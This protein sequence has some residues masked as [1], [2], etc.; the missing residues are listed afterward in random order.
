[1]PVSTRVW[2]CFLAGFFALGQ[3]GCNMAPKSWHRQAALRNQELYKQGQTLQQQLAATNQTAAQKD[4]QNRDLKERLD[5]A[6]KR[7]ANLNDERTQLHSRYV[8]L[9]N[10]LKN[11]QNPLSDSATQRFRQLGEKYPGF[12]FDPETGV[13]KFSSDLLFDSGS[14]NIKSSAQPLLKDFAKIMNEGAAGDLK[15]LVAGH[16]DNKPIRKRATA[17]KHPTNWHLSTNRANEVVVTLQKSGV[18]S[19]RMSSA[20][21]GEHQPLVPNSNDS[22]RGKNRRVEIFILAPDSAAVAG[23]DPTE[24]TGAVK[25]N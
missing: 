17:S 16:T 11:L 20:G 4:A 8:N 10:Q 1:M 5:L 23:W 13:S 3:S 9:Q 22:N 24:K 19:A 25:R 12:N 18:K 7:L 15:I 6:R 14:A 21:Y 2:V